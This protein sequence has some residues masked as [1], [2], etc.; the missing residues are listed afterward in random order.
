MRQIIDFVALLGMNKK[1]SLRI[2]AV[3][4]FPAGRSRCALGLPVIQARGQRRA[5]AGKAV[6]ENAHWDGGTAD[7][8]WTGGLTPFPTHS[9]TGGAGT[10]KSV[11]ES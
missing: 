7:W 3:N 2:A 8:A 11:P 5:T 4:G 1:G 6:A 9:N 10:K